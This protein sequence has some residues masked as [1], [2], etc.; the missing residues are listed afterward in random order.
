MFS[1]DMGDWEKESF[2]VANQCQRFLM[3]HKVDGR[4]SQ[5]HL[6]EDHYKLTLGSGNNSDSDL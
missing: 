3:R 4:Q 5:S 6:G 2:I 1:L